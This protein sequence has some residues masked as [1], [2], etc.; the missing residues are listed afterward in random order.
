MRDPLPDCSQAPPESLHLRSLRKKAPAPVSR[1]PR[2][3]AAERRRTPNG[4][5]LGLR[6]DRGPSGSGGLFGESRKSEQ[7]P[8]RRWL[9]AFSPSGLWR[10]A[11]SLD[12]DRCI[13]SIKGTE[14][15][16]RSAALHGAIKIPVQ[17]A[18]ATAADPALG[19]RGADPGRRRPRGQSSPHL[20]SW[21]ACPGNGYSARSSWSKPRWMVTS[22]PGKGDRVGTFPSA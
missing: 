4:S 11:Q 14:K 8:P 17:P 7:E 10:A 1:P 2:L 16:I 19:S 5:H 3:D 6:L 22:Q 21:R 13:V 20:V 15:W 18:A 9:P 12:W